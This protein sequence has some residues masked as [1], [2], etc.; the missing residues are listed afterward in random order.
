MFLPLFS[1][2]HVQKMHIRV[3]DFPQRKHMVYLG[4]AWIAE[5][6]KNQESFW[7]TQEEY[8]EQGVSRVLEK[9]GPRS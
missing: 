9:L 8:Y 3:E 1:P 4:G 2:M 7:I 5:I 6:M